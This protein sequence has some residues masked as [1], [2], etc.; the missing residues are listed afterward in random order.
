MLSRRK[1]NLTRYAVAG[2]LTMMI[3]GMGMLLGLVIEG[4]RIRY[5]EQLSVQQKLDFSSLQVQ[6]SYVDQLG[7]ENDCEKLSK[8]FD[9]SINNLETARLKLVSYSEN[10]QTNKETFSQLKRDYTL[11]QMQY[12][13]FS[14]KVKQRCSKNLSTILYFYSTNRNCPDC[15]QQEFVLN[16][17]KKRFGD[18]LITFALDSDYK[19]EPMIGV[20]RNNYDINVY[21]TLIIDEKKFEGFSSMEVVLAEICRNLGNDSNCKASYRQ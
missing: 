14:K 2:A 10:T 15:G 13:L 6:Y 8:T 7:A 9:E 1:V 11:S 18:S 4:G 21:P 16:Y 20:L 5:I 3:F 17:L 19:E 12:W